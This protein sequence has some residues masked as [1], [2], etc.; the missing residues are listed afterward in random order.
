MRLVLLAMGPIY[1]ERFW[2]VK[3]RTLNNLVD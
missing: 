1:Y 2:A 3:Y